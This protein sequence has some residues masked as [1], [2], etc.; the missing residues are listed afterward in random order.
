MRLNNKLVRLGSNQTQIIGLAS[1]LV[2]GV[3][4]GAKPAFGLGLALPDQDA[5]ATARGNA[6]IATAN[7]PSAIFYNPAGITQLGGFNIS[8][9]VYGIVDGDR[10][11]GPNGGVNSKTIWSAIPQFY[12]TYSLSNYNLTFGL[13]AFAPYGLRMEWPDKAPFVSAGETG[14]MEYF[15][16]S[17]IVAWQITPEL[18]VAAG[19][20]FNY[21]QVDLKEIETFDI[22][23]ARPGPDNP[24]TV[25]FVNHYRGSATDVGYTAGILYHPSE[26]HYFGLTYRSAT[27]MNYNGHATD[28]SAGYPFRANVAASADFHFPA[29]LGGGYSYRPNDKWN[30]EADVNW[31]DWSS[32]K[33]VP[34]V[35]SSPGVRAEDTLNFDWSPSWMVD[36]GVTRYLRNNWRVSGGYIYSEN[37]V[38]DRNFN[39]LIPDSDRHIFSIGV[40]KQCGRF[41]WDAAYQLAWAPSRTVGGDVT[42]GGTAGGKY[43]FL[44]HALTINFGYRF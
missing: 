33:T 11:S 18:S 9:G 29:T 26:H 40:G 12:S 44:S 5:F 43:E 25:N 19:P 16:G 1:A 24:D 7:D 34:L 10:Y 21:S 8:T 38:P 27:E 23:F 2:L 22:P 6:F 15:R 41:S 4:G 14:D 32:L 39:P 3:I 42:A 36:A 20:S 37:S 13:G 35:S 30:F 17:A 31:T 28:L